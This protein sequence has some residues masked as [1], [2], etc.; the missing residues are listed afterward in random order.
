MP[1]FFGISF[2]RACIQISGG[3]SIG[4]QQILEEYLS[5]WRCVD[6]QYYILNGEEANVA[7]MEKSAGCYFLKV[8]E[9]LEVVEVYVVNILGMILNDMDLATS[10][11]EKAMLP[12]DRRQVIKLY[13][14][15]YFRFDIIEVC[16][17]YV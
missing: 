1:I 15:S 16:D 10:W 3:F 6:E 7:H 11:V 8:D 12:E 14:A 4:C 13:L 2:G 17:L 9:Y 5:K